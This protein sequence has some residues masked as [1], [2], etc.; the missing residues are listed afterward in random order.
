MK[1]YA[2]S[3][4]KKKAVQRRRPGDAAWVRD[5]GCLRQFV[6]SC[7]PAPGHMKSRW[8]CRKMSELIFASFR[9]LFPVRFAHRMC[10]FA[11]LPGSSLADVCQTICSKLG[12]HGNPAGLPEPNFDNE[13]APEMAAEGSH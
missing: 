2:L 11:A 12:L 9:L 5:R 6:G 13:P 7:A 1:G 4:A 3:S 10:G 8:I